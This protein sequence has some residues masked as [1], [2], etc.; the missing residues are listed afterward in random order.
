MHEVPR[1]LISIDQIRKMIEHLARS[2]YT[3]R[4]QAITWQPWEDMDSSDPPCLQR[5]WLRVMIDKNG[6]WWLNMNVSFRSRDGYMA[7]FMN[8]DA[9]ICLMEYIADEVGKIAGRK[10][11]LGRYCDRSD[12]Y[13]IYGKDIARFRREFLDQL[14]ARSFEER[15]WTSEFLMPMMLEA[16]DGILEKIRRK[17]AGE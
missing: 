14:Y 7:A 5:I 12:S 9:F 3:R 2:P 15:T 4:C 11:H 8:A 10:V 16:K 1:H 13:H 6:E 17:D